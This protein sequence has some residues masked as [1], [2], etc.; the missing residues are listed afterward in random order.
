M[1]SSII[2]N[3]L[4]EPKFKPGRNEPAVVYLYLTYKEQPPLEHL[5]GS[6]VR[7]LVEGSKDKGLPLS[8]KTLWE[9]QRFKTKEHQNHPSL[10]DLDEI[11]A[12]LTKGRQVYIIVDALDE[13]T[14]NLRK[15]LIDHLRKIREDINLLVTSRLLEGL[16]KMVVGFKRLDVVAQKEDIHKY[17]DD[18]I[19]KA[20]RLQDM[21]TREKDLRKEIRYKVTEKC[22]QM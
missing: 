20:D 21:F 13:C 17:I 18:E 22:S 19:T 11:L 9:S 7:Q 3:H 2:V 14:P 10:R 4:K 12:E 5:L 6:I 15:M 16:D 1:T 8:I